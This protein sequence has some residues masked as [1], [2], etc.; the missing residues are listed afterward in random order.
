MAGNVYGLGFEDT[1][2]NVNIARH[3]KLFLVYLCVILPFQPQM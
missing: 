3:M 1:L 2:V